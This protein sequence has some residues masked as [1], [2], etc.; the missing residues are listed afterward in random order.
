MCR[1]RHLFYRLLLES[2]VA[3][4]LLGFLI[5]LDWRF[6]LLNARLL[7]KAALEHLVL[8]VAVV[9][10]VDMLFLLVVFPLH[11]SLIQDWFDFHFHRCIHDCCLHIRFLPGGRLDIYESIESDV[12][13]VPA[14]GARSS[15]RT[16]PRIILR[17]QGRG[18]PP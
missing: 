5:E 10:V 12:L 17:S 18:L 7:V 15:K 9:T 11:S 14:L 13:R 3:G 6:C 8:D 16:L 2:L 1:F 4:S